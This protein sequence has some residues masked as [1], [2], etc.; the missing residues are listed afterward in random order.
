[1]D[2]LIY[3]ISIPVLLFVAIVAPLWVVMHYSSKR[4]TQSQLSLKE[5]TD[6]EHLF[7]SAEKMKSRV[8]TLEA[9]LDVETPDWRKS[10]K[11][12]GSEHIS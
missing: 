12:N 9:I 2:V 3:L 4:R 7:A 10:T 5:H 11:D 6:L 8:E 1:M